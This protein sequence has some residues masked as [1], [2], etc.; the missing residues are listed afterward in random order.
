MLAWVREALRESHADEKREHEEAIARLQAEYNRLQDRIDAMY[1]DKLD[2]QI[3]ADFFDR[4]AGE[5]RDEQSR[6]L[7][8][9]ERHQNA[10][11]SYL[12]EGVQLAGT[13]AIR[14]AACSSGR[15]RG[16]SAAC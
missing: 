13:G 7:R 10:N 12:D 15:R 14:A 2:G 9:I 16:K 6:C 1:V 8:D 3:D 5:W 11:Q 4:K